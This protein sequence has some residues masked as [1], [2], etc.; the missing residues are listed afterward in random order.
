MVAAGEVVADLGDQHVPA[1]VLARV[2]DDV[3]AVVAGQQVRAADVVRADVRVPDQRLLRE[4]PVAAVLG[5]APADVTVVRVV[6]DHEQH[7]VT[8]V[9]RGQVVAEDPCVRRLAGAG[10]EHVLGEHGL[11]VRE[12]DAVPGT[13]EPGGVVLAVE[14]QPE[15][16]DVLVPQDVRRGDMADLVVRLPVVG[17]DRVRRVLRE[18]ALQRVPVGQADAAGGVVRGV[19]EVVAAQ[20]VGQPVVDAP[21]AREDDLARRVVLQ[22]GGRQERPQVLVVRE[23]ARRRGCRAHHRPGGGQSCRRRDPGDR[24]AQEDP[25]AR[26]PRVG[27]AG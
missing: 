3:R 14:V 24:P 27:R 26:L 13:G 12:G 11:V 7:H 19:V 18:R 8:G 15:L 9:P 6:V 5:P 17:D 10:R 20:R 1:G 4:G 2:V 22:L 23:A 25:A 21:D 16:L